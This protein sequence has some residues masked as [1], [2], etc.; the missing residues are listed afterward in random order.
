VSSKRSDGASDAGSVDNVIRP[1]NAAVIE[2]PGKDL[3][4][5]LAL[6]MTKFIEE[7]EYQLNYVVPMNELTYVCIQMMINC[8]SHHVSAIT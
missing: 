1:K 5:E 3:K 2:P 4:M 6:E 7:I 8:F